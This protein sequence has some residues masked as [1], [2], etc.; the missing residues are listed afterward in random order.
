MILLELSPDNP[1]IDP[2]DV[3]HVTVLKGPCTTKISG[4]PGGYIVMIP[5]KVADI[6]ITIL[7]KKGWDS[8]IIGVA[9][10]S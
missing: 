1:I 6:T 5:K 10:Y 3:A 9:P 8:N 2:A 4:V 7:R